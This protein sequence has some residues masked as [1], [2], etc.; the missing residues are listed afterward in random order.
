MAPQRQVEDYVFKGILALAGMSIGVNS[1][2]VKDKVGEM[3]ASLRAVEQAV[4]SL[5]L[6]GAVAQ[7]QQTAMSQRIEQN[8]TE[9]ERYHDRL[10]AAEEAIV[11]LR[12]RISR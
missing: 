9:L 7:Q 1:F 11:T 3:T 12:A 8:A 5:E 10:H 2:L 4:R 6:N